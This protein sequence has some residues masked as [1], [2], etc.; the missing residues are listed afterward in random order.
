MR[1]SFANAYVNVKR[2]KNAKFIPLFDEIEG[3][4]AKKDKPKSPEE[5]KKER[6][7]FFNMVQQLG[8]GC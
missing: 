3:K 2:D 4:E 7:E 1:N 8:G 5:L 6:E